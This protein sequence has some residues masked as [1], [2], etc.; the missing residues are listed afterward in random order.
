MNF[1]NQI[2]VIYYKN[3]DCG[4]SYTPYKGVVTI[5]SLYNFTNPRPE[6]PYGYKKE[7]NVKYSARTAIAVKFPNATGFLEYLLA[8]EETPLSWNHYCGLS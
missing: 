7:L 6:D 2:Q 1:L 3:D 4:L 8:K 5:K